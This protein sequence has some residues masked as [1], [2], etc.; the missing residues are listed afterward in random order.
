MIPSRFV[1]QL[2]L[3]L[4]FR[5]VGERTNKSTKHSITNGARRAWWPTS[6]CVVDRMLDHQWPRG[7]FRDTLAR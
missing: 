5:R 7:R 4:C 1:R 3:M 6:R 2:L